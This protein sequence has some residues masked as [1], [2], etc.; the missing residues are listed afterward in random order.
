M[1]QPLRV[2]IVEDSAD[3][4]LLVL[5]ELRRGGYNVTWERVETAETMRAALTRQPW[6]IVISDYS[7]P[8]FSGP[9]AL[10]LLRASGLDLPLI[11]VSGT[12]G[13]ELAVAAMKAGA[14]DYLMKGNLARLV[15]A[16]QRGAREG[17]GPPK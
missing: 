10:E 5:R 7:M 11:L 9:A 14:N 1:N 6:E 2:L 12:V 8:H 17:G 13:E 15:P 16:H 4:A 3:D